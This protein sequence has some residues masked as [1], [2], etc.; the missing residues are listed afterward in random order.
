MAQ[1]Q[2]NDMWKETQQ[3]QQHNKYLQQPSKGEK[4]EMEKGKDTPTPKLDIQHYAWH[5]AGSI[6]SAIS[7]TLI[8]LLHSHKLWIRTK[9]HLLS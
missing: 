2:H 3:Q 4:N 9:K 6:P 8:F 7:K 5:P 1:T